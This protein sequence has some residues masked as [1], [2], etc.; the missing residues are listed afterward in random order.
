M[1]L[2]FGNSSLVNHVKR[3]REREVGL[4]NLNVQLHVSLLHP[5]MPQGFAVLFTLAHKDQTLS[6]YLHL[7]TVRETDCTKPQSKS[8]FAQYSIPSQARNLLPANKAPERLAIPLQIP[9][10]CKALPAD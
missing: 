2:H 9:S 4:Q 6:N 3:E 7:P 5:H 10:R 8:N 1:L